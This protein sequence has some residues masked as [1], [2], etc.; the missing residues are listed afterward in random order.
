MR[1][2]FGR[3]IKSR[4]KQHST[5][6]PPMLRGECLEGR[7]LLAGD[8]TMVVQ[9]GDLLLTGDSADNEFVVERQFNG[10]MRVLGI[11]TNIILDGVSA[12]EHSFS[13]TN[14][15]GIDR[16]VII[17]GGGGADTITFDD[18][19]VGRFFQADLGD[20]ND[21]LTVQ[22]SDF[23]DT[24]DV[25]GGLGND[26]IDLLVSDITG[27]T[28]INGNDGADTL[29]ADSLFV[30]GGFSFDGGIG[31]DRVDAYFIEEYNAPSP[32][33]TTFIGGSGND[34][35]NLTGTTAGTT[36]MDGGDGDDILFN[37]EPTNSSDVTIE[38]GT[39]I[40]TV[41]VQNGTISG[42]LAIHVREG[43]S[44][45]TEPIT[46]SMMTVTGATSAR[47]SVGNQ[48]VTMSNNMLGRVDVVLGGG[49]DRVLISNSTSAI[50][51]VKAGSG[52]DLIDLSGNTINA[53]LLIDAGGGIDTIN[54]GADDVFNFFV[55]IT[56]GLNHNDVGNL[57]TR[58]LAG[59]S[60]T[61]L[62]NLTLSPPT[63]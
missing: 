47:G 17:S 55:T 63:V 3:K 19:E 13:M 9:N 24:F 52:E 45:V 34:T 61:S 11:N 41:T 10:V 20:G 18:L 12:S 22:D 30:S 14:P 60:I 43:I 33:A 5:R 15:F 26:S 54:T 4:R 25:T 58:F 57:G 8:V 40:D 56:G 38:G 32:I 28:T 21:S 7:R 29:Y 6:R 16:D 42:K 23:M 51:N 1:S 62:E 35:I 49:E 37:S 50:T 53:N 27:D 31:D 44:G 36:L 39:G 59:A 48:H 46:I 2:W